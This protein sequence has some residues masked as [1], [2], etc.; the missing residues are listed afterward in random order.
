MIEVSHVSGFKKLNSSI[1]LRRFSDGT[2]GKEP[3]CK[4][5]NER[6]MGSDPGSGRS[7]GG[8]RGKPLQCSFPENPMDREPWWATVHWVTKSWTITEVT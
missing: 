6:D 7:P 1:K 4:S 3:T 8:G 5:G 2:R